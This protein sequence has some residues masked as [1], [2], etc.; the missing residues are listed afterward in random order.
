MTGYIYSIKNT[1]TGLQ[2][3]GSTRKAL[4]TR[5]SQ[6]KS[7]YKTSAN[8]CSSHI[9]LRDGID[10]CVIECLEELGDLSSDE[11][12]R[13]EREHQSLNQCVNKRRAYTT[14]DEKKQYMKDY[15]KKA[16]N[17]VRHLEAMN[18]YTLRVADERRIALLT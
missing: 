7:D 3:I 18:R 1:K 5:L 17:Y 6:H 4:K 10:D 8:R 15:F 14:A 12:R 16:D 11:I 2:Y 9:V 13:K